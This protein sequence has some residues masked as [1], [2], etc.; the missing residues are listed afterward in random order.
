M[1]RY[2][3]KSRFL[4]GDQCQKRL[5]LEVNQRELMS[6]VSAGTQWLFDQGHEIG[7]LATLQFPGGAEVD[8]TDFFGAVRHTKELMASDVPAIFEATFAA[9]R[10]YA[11]VD[12]LRRTPGGWDIIEVKSSMNK[13][14]VHVID[15]AF[16]SI[17][18]ARAGIEVTGHF[19]MHVNQEFVYPDG[20]ELLVLD[21]V[22]SDVV[23]VRARVESQLPDLVSVMD[24][25]EPDVSIGLHCSSPYECSF[26]D[27]CWAYLPR[28]SV[29][30]IPSIKKIKAFDLVDAGCLDACN[31]LEYVTLSAKQTDYVNLLID[32]APRYDIEGVR[33]MFAQL[34]GPLYFMDF[35][36]DRPA[37]PRIT[38][39]SPGA[40]L[41]Y[42]YSCH[43]VQD[44][45]VVSH[46]E[47]LHDDLT[48]PREEFARRLIEDLGETG[49]IIVYHAPTEKGVLRK[50][51]TSFPALAD[52]LMAI[53]ERIW[54]LLVVI[55]DH[56]KHPG[57]LGSNSIKAVL[58]ILVPELTYEGLPVS[59]G[60]DAGGMWNR[61]IRMDPGPERDDVRRDLL[62]YCGLDTLAMVRTW[63]ALNEIVG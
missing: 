42:Q 33:T 32:G 24:G 2:L 10:L 6:P 59:N 50:L 8:H 38:G 53:H 21:E 47:Y 3:S 13:K 55:R 5:W 48:D 17:L 36:Y 1:A 19:L 26:K 41:P 44:N 27:H 63:E 51:A 30:T 9:D 37:I 15:I 43:I 61:M 29:L 23:A 58:P 12:V 11:R 25:A 40:Q 31:A 16:Q 39:L 22:S 60:T 57:F 54:D 7:R 34:E 4:S 46:T 18:L 62:A 49:S 14:D 52:P 28:E 45:Q 35:E 56:V 20:G